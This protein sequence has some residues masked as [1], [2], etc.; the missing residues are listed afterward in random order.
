MTFFL[1]KVHA[2]A[3]E[4]IMTVAG[5]GEGIY[6]LLEKYR[7]KTPC[8]IEQ[9]RKING[10][11]KNQGLQ[12]GKEYKL[13]IFLYTYNGKSIRTTTGV[14][15]L[16]WAEKVQK[17]NEIMVRAGV[18]TGDYRDNRELWVPYH[19]LYCKAEDVPLEE[20]VAEVLPETA[21]VIKPAKNV[22]LR[23]TYEIFGEKYARVPLESTKL[24]GKVFYISSGHGGPDPGAIGT[25]G[26][27]SLCED[28]YAYDVGLRL[29]RNLLSYGAT[30]YIITRD[31][32]DGIR[33]GEILPCDKD[34]T[35]WVGQR[36]P[37]G[38]SER[39]FQRSD[40][41]NMLFEKNQSQGVRYQRL[42]A[43]HVDSD[44]RTEQIDMY[45]YYR[46]EDAESQALSV[47]LYNK[48]KA[49][50]DEFRK[51][52]GYEGKVTSRDLHM[53]RETL[54]PAVYIELGNIKNRTDQSRLV[55]EENRQLMANWLF[56][57]LVQDALDK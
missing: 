4:Y 31:E 16:P 14:S 8:N 33:E 44:D 26:S 42:I 2:N 45:F 3:P 40:Q 55:V 51:G 12:N 22:P 32:N 57:G 43:I 13:P 29:S 6:S 34:E 17:Y 35:L 18:K 39:L 25:Y 9:F 56:E 11:K 50:Y 52:R 1:G 47:T 5:Q 24:S 37:A 46:N 23:G 21:A 54:P 15:D 49:K 7:A 36:I 20:V 19:M 28:E 48:I 38:Q 10:L 53:L 41:I 27:H 30:V